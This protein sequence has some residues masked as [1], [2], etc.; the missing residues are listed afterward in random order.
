[1]Y[2]R[3]TDQ[4]VKLSKYIETPS[5]IQVSAT[6]QYS[7]RNIE[8]PNTGQKFKTN[9]T[10]VKTKYIEVVSDSITTWILLLQ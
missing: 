10:K 3:V 9:D 5:K 2:W 6:N 7:S 4:D 1:M 8:A